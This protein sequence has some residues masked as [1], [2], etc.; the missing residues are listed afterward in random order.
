MNVVWRRSFIHTYEFAVLPILFR[1]LVM[2]ALPLERPDLASSL[3]FFSKRVFKPW[4]PEPIEADEPSF[5]SDK[6]RSSSTPS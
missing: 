6:Q 1:D 2:D 4:D 3:R 5:D